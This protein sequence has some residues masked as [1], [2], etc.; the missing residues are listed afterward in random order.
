[1]YSKTLL[2]LI[3]KLLVNYNYT[4]RKYCKETNDLGRDFDDNRFRHDNKNTITN[5]VLIIIYIRILYI[6]E[7][8]I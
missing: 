1:M 3:Y 5:Y 7:E 6:V 8:T 4:S 2:K